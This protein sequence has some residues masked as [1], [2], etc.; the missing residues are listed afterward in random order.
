MLR[1]VLLALI[2]IVA[3]LQ[4]AEPRVA[5]PQRA[6]AAKGLVLGSILH[7]RGAAV[8]GLFDLRAYHLP[9]S[10]EDP[11]ADFET[12]GRP[13]PVELATAAKSFRVH[14]VPEGRLWIVADSEIWGTQT[15]GPVDVLPGGV[16]RAHVVYAVDRDDV[17]EVVA[18][19]GAEDPHL[20]ADDEL[21]FETDTRVR[22]PRKLERGHCRFL[23]E[24]L[25][26][27][28][29]TVSL[30]S[31]YYGRHLRSA[32]PGG[33]LGWELPA[34]CSLKLVVQDAATGV[35]LTRYSVGRFDGLEGSDELFR[36]LWEPRPA[37]GVYTRLPCSGRLLI[38][39]PGYRE[40]EV[41]VPRDLRGADD[42]TLVV[43]LDPALVLRG[44]VVDSSG[45]AVAGAR[46]GL[47]RIAKHLD[48]HGF[49]SPPSPRTDEDGG[50]E[51]D[52]LRHG[53]Y[54][55]RVQP[56]FPGP[57]VSSEVTFDAT[58]SLVT[59]TLPP[60]GRLVGRLVGD[61]PQG[62]YVLAESVPATATTSVAGLD[63]TGRFSFPRLP[64][65]P[66]KIWLVLERGDE[67]R[68]RPL[69]VVEIVPGMNEQ[70]FTL[71]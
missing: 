71:D 43:R 17:L 19:H 13:L 26:P 61:L 44:R 65:G 45:R 48:R 29:G 62:A 38:R 4:A 53:D 49:R 25:D 59:L 35:E 58:T 6:G 2:Q 16:R 67:R 69:G 20:G 24:G 63:E 52:G 10:E 40:D 56:P 5:P 7:D 36:K 8:F 12:R 55:L 39:A 47:E 1:F 22:T 51:F 30:E 33:S 14:D 9:C 11:G 18:L 42:P 31:A 41:A 37:D 3:M 60:T 64:V 21:R 66:V 46:V 68:G 15:V 54:R 28:R 50:F 34:P 57:S 32:S 70:D 27:E 23:F